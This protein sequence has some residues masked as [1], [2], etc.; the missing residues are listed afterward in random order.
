MRELA[1]IRLVGERLAWYPPGAADGARWL[2]VAEERDALAA[3]IAQ[4][5][6]AAIFAVPGEDLRLLRITVAPEER[7]HLDK[8]LPFMLEEELVEDV[9]ELHFARVALADHELAVAVCTNACMERYREALSVLPPVGQWLPEPLLLPWQEGEW[10]L[11][12]EDGRAVLRYGRSEGFCVEREL[13]PMMLESLLQSG[14]SPEQVVI[15]GDDQE[16]DLGLMPAALQVKPQWRRGGFYAALLV[17]DQP[18]PLLNLRQ[19][20]FAPRLPLERW[21]RQWRVAA[22][23]LAAAFAIHLVAGWVQLRQLEAQN[24]ALRAEIE[25]TY[26][27]VIPRGMVPEPERQLRRQLDELGGTASGSGFSSLMAR[28]GEVVSNNPGSSLVS[29]N[30]ND[31]AAEMRLNILAADYEEVERIRAGFVDAGLEASLE[32]SSASGE[33]VRARLRIG[34]RT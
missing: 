3:I 8:S 11:V 21:W 24:L 12:L 27:Q 13:L 7:R 19:G 1:I 16:A 25:Q 5:R 26:R 23:L 9:D 4:R 20:D 2:D 34:G 6:Q 22:V 33:Q 18:D 31:R 32:N 29:V 30:Y 15:Y 17:A 28:V 14:E 10:C